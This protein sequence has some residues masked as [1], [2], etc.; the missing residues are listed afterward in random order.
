MTAFRTRFLHLSIRNW[1]FY[2]AEPFAAV[3]NPAH[4]LT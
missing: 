1:V 3:R 4:L 2:R